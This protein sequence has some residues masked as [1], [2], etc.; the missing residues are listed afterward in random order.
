MPEILRRNQSRVLRV[1]P[2]P[3]Q[4]DLN[5]INQSLWVLECEETIRQGTGFM[6]AGIGLVTCQ[7]VLGTA[8]HAI[9]PASSYQRFS[10][11]VLAQNSVVD[12]AILSIDT[13]VGLELTRGSADK[14]QQMTHIAVAG[15]P[16]FRL[17]DSGIISPGLVVG[18]R[19]MSGIRKIL[20][21]APIIAGNVTG[22]D[23]MEKAQETEEHGIIPI[24]VVKY[25]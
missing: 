6:L 18:F 23:R 5:I 16:N 4:F 19:M 13:S 25:L 24:D 20:T 14:L 10:V 3:P 22:Y 12:L 9:H 7:H 8:T 21:N 17:G 1:L 2:S 11:R 15:F